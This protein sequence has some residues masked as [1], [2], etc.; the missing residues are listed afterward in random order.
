MKKSQKL[1][2]L[3]FEYSDYFLRMFGAERGNVA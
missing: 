1:L 2:S 3:I